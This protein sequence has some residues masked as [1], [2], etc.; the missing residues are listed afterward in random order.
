MVTFLA[1]PEV[2]TV[3][4]YVSCD[5][6]FLILKDLEEFWTLKSVRSIEGVMGQ[7]CHVVS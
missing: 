2:Q 7:L 1:S 4:R 6:Q 3:P 5:S